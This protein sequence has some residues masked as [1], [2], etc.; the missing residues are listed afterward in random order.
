[1]SFVNTIEAFDAQKLKKTS[2]IEKNILPDR[3]SKT[4][5]ERF[6]PRFNFFI[7]FFV[8]IELEKNNQ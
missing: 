4:F 3:E 5:F 2:T 7:Y 1:L 6:G 8:A